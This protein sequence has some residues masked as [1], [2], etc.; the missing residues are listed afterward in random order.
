MYTPLYI[1]TYYS[2][3]SSLISIDKLIQYAKEHN[4][5]SLAIT[6]NNMFGTMEFYKKCNKVGIKP[7]IGLEILL[8]NDIILFYAKD[9]Q[10]Y[11]TLTKLATIQAT[12]K[13]E[14]TDI[15]KYHDAVIGIV[16]F[17]YHNTYTMIQPLISNLY[18][19]YSTKKEE[20]EALLITK[21]VVFLRKCLSIY[22]QDTEYLKYLY[23]IRD[24][25]TIAD[26]IHYEISNCS[27]DINDIYEFTS[28]ENLFTTNHIA[29]LCNLQFP[30][31]EL[32]L[33]IYQ[34]T[35]GL[36]SHEYLQELS[37]FGLMKRLEGQVRESYAKRLQ[38]ELGIIE[39]MGFSN[40]FLVVYDFIRYAKKNKILV[41][42]GRGSGAGSLVCYS[43]GITDIDPIEYDLLFERFLNP[44]RIT[45]PDIDT[46]FPDVYRDQ[47]IDYVVGKYGEKKVSGIVT[48][49]TLAAKQALRDVARVLNV[50]NFQ[51]DFISK[52][53][54]GF[55][56]LKL[57][58]F[59][60]QDQELRK[61]I[62]SD[63][64]LT[65]MYQIA[66]FIEG[67]PRHT[68]SHAAGI[69]MSQKDLDEVI[70][71]TVSSGNTSVISVCIKPGAIAFTHI[72]LGANSL[73]IDLVI[74][75]IPALA[76]E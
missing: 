41:G 48:F 63:V 6:D 65:Q 36:P 27:L 67:Y 37:K 60:K 14:F 55:T 2:L 64:K 35:K 8:E 7:I 52:R 42:P 71:L 24:G 31:S 46:D 58:D 26:D 54:P 5:S 57:I 73:A 33:P 61:M 30:K 47:V 53:I 20:R 3:L 34:E 66:S 75:I 9:Y 13:I 10:G 15:E 23:M 70:P 69:V 44:E 12:R 76:A 50:P 1:K 59:Y 11:Q 17:A 28:N 21:N 51:I 56:K 25:K 38:Y 22:E 68:S 72:F 18:L 32:L 40:Y 62:D 29:D 45:M 19:G 4:F 16:P 74:P 39:K 49:G 43:L